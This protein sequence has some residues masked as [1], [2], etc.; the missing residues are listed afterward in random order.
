MKMLPHRG[1]LTGDMV[2]AYLADSDHA[3][4]PKRYFLPALDLSIAALISAF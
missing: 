2:L 3:P 1:V 4:N